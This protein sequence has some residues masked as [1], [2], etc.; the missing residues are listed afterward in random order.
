[1]VL[2][3]KLPGPTDSEEFLNSENDR[4]E[5]PQV[6]EHRGVEVSLYLRKPISLQI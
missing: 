1:M 2:S 6:F 4:I 5:V 3:I